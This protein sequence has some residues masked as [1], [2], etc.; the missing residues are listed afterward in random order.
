MV[1][2]RSTPGSTKYLQW[3]TFDE[4]G[5]L[6]K[7]DEGYD[8]V[9]SWL[10]SLPEAKVTWTSPRKEYLKVSAPLKVW[11][12][13]LD[14][15]FYTYQDTSQLTKEPSLYNVAHE[16]SIPA[17]L[18]PHISAIFNTVQVPPPFHKRFLRKNDNDN[19]FFRDDITVESSSAADSAGDIEPMA[20]SSSAV[21]IS[22]L[23]SF[24][25]VPSNVGSAGVRQSVFETSEQAFSPTDLTT[26]QNK[27]GLTVQSAQ[28]PYGYSTS[29]C[30]TSSTPTAYDC[31]EGNL[32]VQYIM[33]LAQNVVSIYWYVGG[34]NPFLSW[35]ITAAGQSNPPLSNSISWG[36]DETTVGSSTLS[37]FN[38][39]AIKLAGMGVTI[40]VSSGDNGI[41]FSDC[42][43]TTS[44]SSSTLSWAGTLPNSW[45]GKGYFPS[46]PATCPY[47]TAVGGTMGLNT[48]GAEIAC[49]S[50][51]GGIITTGGGFS[52]YY[53]TPSWQTKTVNS[54]FSSL[55]KPLPASGYNPKG[56]GYPDV[57]FI[58]VQYQVYINSKIYNLY[59]TSA[60]APVMAALV[61]L[62]NSARLAK[63][64]SSI[65]FLNPTLYSLGQNSSS[66]YNDVTAGN[67]NCC[68]NGDYPATTTTCCYAGFN[69]TSGWDPVTGWGSI[70]YP[71]FAK[72]FNVS[73]TYVASNTASSARSI[74]TTTILLATV[75]SAFIFY[76]MT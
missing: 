67:N 66:N 31:N 10:S 21:T 22:Q 15:M 47:V 60:S 34:S 74:P 25:H 38:T 28:A 36:S 42:R 65:G 9:V 76:F 71:T 17:E 69:A 14:A 1:L 39:E 61:S 27:Y 20:S 45:T 48:G 54:Y 41:S 13:E 29:T 75:A 64:M 23:N 51:L 70:Y 40:L 37:Q 73:T 53:P 62:L 57:S 55:S 59:G 2:E 7:N 26:F 19:K 11:E 5:S 72:A 52:T 33:G 58:A 43:C 6:I 32:D 3:M 30:L 24:Y 18:K 16:Y 50:Q 44:S 46:F 12:I 4:I 35:I 8:S 63:G 68:S 49:Q 56:R